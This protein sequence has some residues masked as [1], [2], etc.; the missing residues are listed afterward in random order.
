MTLEH[1]PIPVLSLAD[2]SLFTLRPVTGDDKD[3]ILNGFER[4]SE[5][6]RYL[7]F[8]SPMPS[9]SRRQ[10]AYLSELD[11]RRHVAIGML[12]GDRPVA[13]GR[14]VRFD[15]DPAEADV[16]VTVIDEYQGRGVGRILVQ[17]LAQI[18]RHRGV[19]W[20]HFDV[21]AENAAMLTV[22]DRLGAV[23][24]PSGPIVH[25]VLDADDVPAPVGLAGDI[26]DM[27]DRAAAVKAG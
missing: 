2:G 7:R 10:L 21:L 22:L 11:H 4:M 26:L 5:R 18:A 24:T 17:A 3:L 20:L 16:A 12:D 14:F 9:L 13:I 19:R 8:L 25:A 1:Q 15:D 27:V 23:R 6:S